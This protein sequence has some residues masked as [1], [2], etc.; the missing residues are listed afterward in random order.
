MVIK[1]LIYGGLGNQLFQLA[2]GEALKI[3]YKN[4]DLKNIDLT[5]Y[6]KTK[7]KWELGFL[8]I[9]PYHQSGVPSNR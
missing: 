1:I 6:A 3:S 9:K 7:R 2:F 8:N 4:K 5:K